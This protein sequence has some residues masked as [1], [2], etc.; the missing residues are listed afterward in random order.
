M[1]FM[2]V[3]DDSASIW[4][5]RLNVKDGSY[6]IP[7][8]PYDQLVPFDSGFGESFINAYQNIYANLV[9]PAN[10]EFGS[11]EIGNVQPI[12]VEFVNSGV[13][14]L[15]VTSV[16]VSPGLTTSLKNQVLQAGERIVEEVFIDEEYRVLGTYLG[17]LKVQHTGDNEEVTIGVSGFLDQDTDQDG[18][19]DSIDSDDDNDGFDDENDAFPLDASENIDSDQDG[20]G[21]NADNDDD[22]DGVSDGDEVDMG[23]DPLDAQSTPSSGLSLLLIKAAIDLKNNTAEQVTQ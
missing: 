5:A 18:I 4:Q 11:V 21:D 6:S 12:S 9:V 13:R 16:V 23:S 19:F 1:S 3:L 15:E 20:V 14:E 17:T 22:G 7:E 2:F 10:V 8:D